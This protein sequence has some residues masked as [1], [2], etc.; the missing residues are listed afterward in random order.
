MLILSN[1]LPYSM[2][3]LM[4]AITLISCGKPSSEN[5]AAPP[6]MPPMPVSTLTMQATTVPISAEAVAQTEGAKEVEVRPRVGGIVLKKLYQEGQAIKAGQAMFLI[7]PVPFQ[8]AVS[9]A[10]A[11][12]AQ[13]RAR[14]EQ[15]QREST[16]LQGLLA[17]QSISQREYD[18][19]VSDHAIAKANVQQAEAQ[20]REAE[21]N[22]SYTQVNAPN[23]GVAGRFAL[24]EGALVAANTSLLATIVQISPIW[25]T[26]SFSEA[27]LK[28]LG[29]HMDERKVQKV[30]L[31]LADGQVYPSAGKLNF[32]ASTI[33]PALGTQQMRAEF[34]NPNSQ[35]LPGQ[36]VRARVVTGSRE[37]VFLVP[38]TAVLTGEQGKFVF[39]AEKS[40]AG[41]TVAGVRP[42][43]EGGWQGTD[44]VVLSGLK[45]GDQVLV[46]NLLKVRPGAPI[47]P[48][49]FGQ[50]PSAPSKP[51]KSVAH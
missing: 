51:S 35:L 3:M 16:R 50:T 5:V 15:T 33:D 45:A 42:I 23:S 31:V 7:D 36:F 41:Q 10:K 18:N 29:G 34:Q 32:A 44:W 47:A 20:V 19:A 28:Q 17:T 4:L 22:L 13:L 37:G 39:V 43:Q 14:V 38:Q 48:H 27:E 30:E 11:Q 25:V 9:Q 8:I 46:D 6:A 26:F 40:P 49:P 21:L 24:S 2:G 12:L 1:K